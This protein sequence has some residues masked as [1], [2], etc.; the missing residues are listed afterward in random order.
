MQTADVYWPGDKGVLETN[1]KYLIVRRFANPQSQMWLISTG[2]PSRDISV[3]KW[4]YHE[5]IN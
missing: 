2:L 4:A 5:C 1:I 3:Y